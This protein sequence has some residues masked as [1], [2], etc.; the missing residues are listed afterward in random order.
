CHRGPA[1]SSVSP[2]RRSCWGWRPRCCR[3]VSKVGGSSSHGRQRRPPVR[4]GRVL[5]PGR[6]RA[7]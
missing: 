6:V 7:A 1:L 4:V 5:R 3:A 2:P